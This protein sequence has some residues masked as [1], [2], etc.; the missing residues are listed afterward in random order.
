MFKKTIP[1]E[2]VT[3]ESVDGLDAG[4]QVKFRNVSIG[5]VTRIE[6][7]ISP[8]ELAKLD[9]PPEITTK[10]A[11]QILGREPKM[12][13]KYIRSGLLEF[14]DVGHASCAIPDELS[15]R[16]SLFLTALRRWGKL[17]PQRRRSARAVEWAGLEN[18]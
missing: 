12:V 14:R 2:T 17:V 10:E 9:L 4:A 15:R 16:N 5:T 7:A 8:E 3:T 1:V 6:P 18:R 13:F 11:A